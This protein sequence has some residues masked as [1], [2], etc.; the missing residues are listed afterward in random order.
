MPCTST[1]VPRSSRMLMSCDGGLHALDHS[2]HR[3]RERCVVLVQLEAWQL[4]RDLP[5]LLDAWSRES[6]HD[7]EPPR[8]DTGILERPHDGT[9]MNIDAGEVL[10]VAAR[11]QPAEPGS[12][13]ERPR[14]VIDLVFVLPRCD[15]EGICGAS[16]ECDQLPERGE[17]RPAARHQK[18]D[19][20]ADKLH[21]ADAATAGI[22]PVDLADAPLERGERSEPGAL[23]VADP[24]PEFRMTEERLV[25]Q[26]DHGGGR[27]HS[28]GGDDSERI[29]L[30]QAG[31]APPKCLV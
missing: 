18:C 29:D 1:R 20:A 6:E 23:L 16:A 25:I 4:R 3:R 14:D 13:Q 2:S 26:L 27:Y 15:V 17:R 30:Q 8:V 12:R 11:D 21:K 22:A 19:V 10:D 7:R 24:V 28:T 31:V 9:H 5:R